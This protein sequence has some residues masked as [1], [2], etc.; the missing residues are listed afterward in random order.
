M[1]AVGLPESDGSLAAA[2]GQFGA[3]V[4]GIG[5]E[6]VEGRRG[7]GPRCDIFDARHAVTRSAEAERTGGHMRY[8]RP[9]PPQITPWASA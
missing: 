9:N 7:R 3:V 4:L 5:S 1:P 2:G 6:L 8:A